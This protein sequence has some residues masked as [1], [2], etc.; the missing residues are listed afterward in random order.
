L[1]DLNRFNQGRKQGRHMAYDTDT[2]A[3]IDR[4]IDRV[5]EAEKRNAAA[6]HIQA[7]QQYE[8]MKAEHADVSA[9]LAKL[10]NE[11]RSG[12]A[13]LHAL[14]ETADKVRTFVRNTEEHGQHLTADS[15]LIKT[16]SSAL[17]ASY[18]ACDGIPF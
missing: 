5:V 7:M 9:R 17:D 8:L 18:D 4:L 11:K 1:I 6:S 2:D 10:Q 14:W 3:L 16:L 15:D 13:V 12:L